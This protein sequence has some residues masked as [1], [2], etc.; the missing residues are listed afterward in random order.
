MSGV[1]EWMSGE[2]C[3]NVLEG[4]AMGTGATG[5]EIGLLLTG[6]FV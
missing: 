4:V 5:T 3:G 2:I 6:A 1:L